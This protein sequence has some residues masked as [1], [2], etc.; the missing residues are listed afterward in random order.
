MGETMPAVVAGDPGRNTDTGVSHGR[1]SR[2]RAVPFNPFEIDWNE[3]TTG[4]W[5]ILLAACKRPTLLQTWQYGVALDKT[6]GGGADFG[7]IRFNGKPIGLVQVQL[8]PIYKRIAAARIHRGPLWI[9][10]E[11]PGEMQ[12]LVLG[13]LRRRYRL[14]RGKFVMFHPELRDT[15]NHRKQMDAAGFVR[16][17]DG[18]A[19]IGLDLTRSVA[20]LRAGLQAKWRN[21]L[22]QGERNGLQMEFGADAKL[23][24]W[25]LQT[26]EDDRVSRAYP[27]PTAAFLRQLA[28]IGGATGM[29]RVGACVHQGQP[30]AG[31]IVVRHGD[32]A[33]YQVGWTGTEGR[34]LRAH[35][36]LLWRIIERLKA[37]GVT[38]FDLGGTNAQGAAA[39]SR[40]KQGLGGEAFTLVGGYI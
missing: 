30:V 27:G 3:C 4:Q 15:P 19:S 17:E 20:Q 18:Y 28:A 40:F 8:R 35:N 32:A 38:W 7:V 34:R 12:K 25:L 29:V 21:K 14:R 1:R 26:Y 36:L 39:V 23:L 13:M 9:H 22:G 37:D 10:D 5:D 16:R 33:T 11:I 31:V 24:D 2:P 6:G